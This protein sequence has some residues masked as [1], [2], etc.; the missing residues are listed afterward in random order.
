[1]EQTAIA[2]AATGMLLAGLRALRGF[3]GGDLMKGV[4]FTAIW[5]AN[6]KHVTNTSPAISRTVLDDSLRIPVSVMAI[7]RSLRLP[8]ETVRRH[9]DA[10]LRDGVCVRSGRGG[11]V[12]PA[13]F[14]LR[15]T[16][17]SAIGYRL[18]MDFLAELR[19]GGVA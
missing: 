5:T 10:L 14:H 18:V 11:L 15:V 9:A 4:V 2:V 17:G 19:R 6:V 16:A 3:W 1:K 12:V 8:Y 7:S 13:S